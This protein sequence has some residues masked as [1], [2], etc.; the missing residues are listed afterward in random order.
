MPRE[1]GGEGAWAALYVRRYDIFYNSVLLFAFSY[2]VGG[3]GGSSGD[4]IINMIESISDLFRISDYQS[5]LRAQV[6]M[7]MHSELHTYM[8]VRIF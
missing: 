3:G 2:F 6:P 1:E 8:N 5:M 4:L 7:G